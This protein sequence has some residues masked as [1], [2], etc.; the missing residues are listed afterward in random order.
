MNLRDISIRYK[1]WRNYRRIRN[2]LDSLTTRELDDVG[3]TRADIDTI[4]RN[5]VR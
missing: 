3:I 1:K 2:E 4:A 5:S